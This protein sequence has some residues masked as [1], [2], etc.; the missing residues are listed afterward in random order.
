[1][2]RGDLLVLFLSNS[3][4]SAVNLPPLEKFCDLSS[5]MCPGAEPEP[6]EGLHSRPQPS[7]LLAF[8]LVSYLGFEVDSKPTGN[9]QNQWKSRLPPELKHSF[10]RSGRDLFVLGVLSVARP[11]VSQLFSPARELLIFFL[12][13]RS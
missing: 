4:L 2:S 1:M 7:Q 10:G 5:D 11:V 13:H 9:Q 8:S 3:D 12:F 6:T